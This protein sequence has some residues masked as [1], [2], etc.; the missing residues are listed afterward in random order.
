MTPVGGVASIL[1]TPVTAVVVPPRLFAQQV[2]VVPAV[3]PGTGTAGEQLVE[4]ASFDTDQWRMTLSPFALP[5]YQPLLPV[6]PV[7]E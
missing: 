2:R 7:I 1:S 3:S 6:I 5:R 4:V